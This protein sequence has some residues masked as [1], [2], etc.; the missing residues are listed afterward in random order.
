MIQVG[1]TIVYKV[2]DGSMK[3]YWLCLVEG[4]KYVF[5][6]WYANPR[7]ATFADYWKMSK[8]WFDTQVRE[9]IIF[10]CFSSGVNFKAS[11]V[12]TC[13]GAKE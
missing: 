4:D 5:F 7:K 13:N 3:F 1:N 11:D 12:L 8:D 9:G 10:P 2:E 6:D